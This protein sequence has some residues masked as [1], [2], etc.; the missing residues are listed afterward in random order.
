[1]EV[2]LGGDERVAIAALQSRFGGWRINQHLDDRATRDGIPI[3]AG[4][5]AASHIVS[6]VPCVVAATID[7]LTEILTEA[8]HA[9]LR[10]AVEEVSGRFRGWKVGYLGL[11]RRPRTVVGQRG[12]FYARRAR[13][14]R[15]S[16]LV[17][18]WTAD[19]LCKEIDSIRRH[20][21]C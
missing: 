16:T 15:T 11:G 17:V 2:T 10:A 9:R 1:M 21:D 3:P 8:N 7:E 5:Y 12:Q 4:H 19:E 13:F 20:A 14:L 18:A 6:E